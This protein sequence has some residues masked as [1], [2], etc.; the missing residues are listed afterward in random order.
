VQARLNVENSPDGAELTSLYRWLRDDP[1]VRRDAKLT[2]VSTPA[3]RGDM[4]GALE[5]VNVVLSNSIALS[6]LVVA[7]ASWIGS[8]RT[9]SPVVRLE[10]NGVTVTIDTDSPEAIEA[11]LRGLRD[12]AE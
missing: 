7:V 8:R 5:L 10:Y 2:A 11:V 12:G 3:Q 4:G 6:S 1:D 9:S